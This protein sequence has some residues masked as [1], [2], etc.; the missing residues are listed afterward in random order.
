MYNKTVHPFA[1][2]PALLSNFRNHRCLVCY[3]RVLNKMQEAKLKKLL[4][5]VDSMTSHGSCSSFIGHSQE[6]LR[7]DWICARLWS[8]CLE[9]ACGWVWLVLA[10][11]AFLLQYGTKVC[12]SPFNT[13]LTRVIGVH[14]PVGVCVCQIPG[15]KQSL[16]PGI[17]TMWLA[18]EWLGGGGVGR[19]SEVIF[20]SS[21]QN[22]REAV[23]IF[24]KLF[25]GWI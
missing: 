15:L 5:H 21:T 14:A 18:D 25:I 20:L 23:K 22:Q 4:V 9:P 7:E 8:T 13:S 10:S 6:A 17:T 12:C 16:N 2:P 19:N 11:C 24:K 1:P 3:Y